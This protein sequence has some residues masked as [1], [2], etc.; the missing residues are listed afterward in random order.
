MKSLHLHI[1]SL[2]LPGGT[3]A[4][5]RAF[6]AALEKA[7]AARLSIAD[8]PVPSQAA[9]RVD[10]FAAAGADTV[11]VLADVLGARLRS[12]RSTENR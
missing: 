12:P 3:P 10:T 9:S 2:S 11:R 7:L 8:T 4:Q 5:Q 1:D 6:V